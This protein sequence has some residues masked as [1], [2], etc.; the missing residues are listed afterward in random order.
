MKFRLSTH[1]IRLGRILP[2]LVFLA[3]VGAVCFSY[4]KRSLYFHDPSER[5]KKLLPENVTAATEGFSFLQSEQGQARFEIKA[6]INLG[7]K[8]NK[9]LLESVTVK[10]FGKDGTRHDTITSDHC[11]YDQEKEEI[12]FSGNV[13]IKLSHGSIVTAQAKVEPPPNDT[14]TAVQMDKITY[15]KSSGKAQTDDPVQFA[16]GNMQGTS[17]GLTYDTNQGSVHLHSNVHIVVQSADPQKPPLELR[18]E[19]LDYLKASGKV[20]MHSNVSLRE[21]NRSLN[22]N[23]LVAWLRETDSSLSRV[24]AEGRVRTVSQDPSLALEVDAEEVSYFLDATGRWLDKVSA[25][26]DVRMWSLDR[27]EKRQLAAETVDMTLKPLTNLMSSLQARGNVSLVMADRKTL[28][29]LRQENPFPD[30]SRDPRF[31]KT[32]AP[33]DKRVNTPEMLVTFSEDGKQISEVQTAQQS[34]LEEFPLRPERDKTILTAK[35]FRLL[36]APESDRIEKFTADDRVRVDVIAIEPPVKTSTSDH[37]EAFF[38]ADTRQLSRLRQFGNFRYREADHDAQAGEALYFADNRTTVLKD[39][40]VVKDASSR[41]SADNF[42]FHP[43]QNLVKARGNI[44]TVFENREKNAQPGMFQSE[45]PVF[46]SADFLDVETQKGIATYRQR[47]KLWQEDQVIRGSTVVLYRNEKRL[48]ANTQ[49]VSLFYLE[50]KSAEEKKERKP[51]T[52]Q[53]EQLVYEDKA[54]KATYSHNVR[55]NS[56]TGKLSSNQL[57]VFLKDENNRKSVERMLATGKVRIEQPGKLATSE[58][59]E[60]F[61]SEKKVILTGGMPR[62]LDSER[63]STVGPRLTMFFE[64]G[65]ITVAGNPET[66]VITRQRVT[67]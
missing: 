36:F 41:T 65:S 22:A 31:D 13:V 3:V 19:T 37:L 40:P 63:G 55:M 5:E 27:A 4:Y 11:E 21:G 12:V 7:F 39:N 50:Q 18:C 25:R 8:D 28:D 42:E 14:L 47:A 56:E 17:R 45:K 67:H 44:R 53:S 10:V 58:S 20:D 9:N 57:E 2:A 35:A 24:D 29:I 43:A 66:R 59:A 61:Q 16:R 52:V 48:E 34:L 15:L 54:Q 26:R 30:F 33:G 51:T 32:S 6:K 38:D 23:R 1:I 46:A 49:V 64:D 62:V 60:F